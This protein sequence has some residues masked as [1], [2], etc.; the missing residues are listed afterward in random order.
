MRIVRGMDSHYFDHPF[1][2]EGEIL[3]ITNMRLS[4]QFAH[5]L[6]ARL[7]QWPWNTPTRPKSMPS[8]R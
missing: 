2:G 5:K 6:L 8:C 1:D 4:L 3:R 7:E